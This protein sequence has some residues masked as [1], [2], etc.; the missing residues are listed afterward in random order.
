MRRRLVLVALLTA[1][2]LTVAASAFAAPRGLLWGNE[3]FLTRRAFDQWL[4]PRGLSYSN[5]AAKHPRGRLILAGALDEPRPLA[6]PTPS[7]SATPVSTAHATVA[8][9]PRLTRSLPAG[10][11]HRS[12]LLLALLAAALA[13]AGLALL[14]LQRFATGSPRLLAVAE[15]RP[16]LAA[17]AIAILIGILVAR[18]SG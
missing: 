5:W 15:R 3:R 7:A 16:M 1:G 18:L 9:A 8:L 17:P 6:P 11:G 12:G 14:P 10:H 2:S 4:A 13:L